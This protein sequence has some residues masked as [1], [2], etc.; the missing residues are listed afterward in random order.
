MAMGGRRCQSRGRGASHFWNI[1][2]DEIGRPLQRPKGQKLWNSQQLIPSP[3]LIPHLLP[4]IIILPTPPIPSHEIQRTRPTQHL[5]AR[6]LQL[7]STDSFLRRRLKLPVIR[8]AQR[9]A[10]LAGDVDF[11]GGEGGGAG[12]E[13]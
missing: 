2:V 7:P 11:G 3:T 6:K 10:E 4:R 9:L 1:K 12:F 13:D 8:A 5:P